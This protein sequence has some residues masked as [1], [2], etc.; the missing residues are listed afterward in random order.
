[1]QTFVNIT[2][3]DFIVNAIH[4]NVGLSTFLQSMMVTK[5]WRLYP[6]IWAYNIFSFDLQPHNL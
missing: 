4:W 5:K 1:M 6:E 2:E 3:G